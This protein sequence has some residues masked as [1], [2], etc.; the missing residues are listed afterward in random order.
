MQASLTKPLFSAFSSSSA[1]IPLVMPFSRASSA[2]ASPEPRPG[3][4]DMDLA[5]QLSCDVMND[6]TDMS[7]VLDDVTG[8]DV[9]MTKASAADWA[10]ISTAD[11]AAVA[12]AVKAV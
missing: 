7:V 3:L 1:L 9:A 6:V 2:P 10:E 11:I 5:Q 12:D 8:D 4:H